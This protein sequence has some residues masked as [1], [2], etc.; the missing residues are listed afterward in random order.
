VS[1]HYPVVMLTCSPRDVSR[2]EVE[3]EQAGKPDRRSG[4]G[5]LWTI[6]RPRCCTSCHNHITSKA[7]RDLG[8]SVPN[9]ENASNLDRRRLRYVLM[10]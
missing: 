9:L 7:G 6:K 5:V 10:G 1:N 4:A 8:S 3:L 2:R